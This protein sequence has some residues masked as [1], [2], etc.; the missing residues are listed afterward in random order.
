[1]LR[2]YIEIG[3]GRTYPALVSSPLHRI[4][5][6]SPIETKA[7]PGAMAAKKIANSFRRTWGPIF[8]EEPA[9]R[10]QQQRHGRHHNAR[11]K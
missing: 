7:E 8:R 1:M 5:P 2:R 6:F 4:V 3:T 10:V 9:M 11:A